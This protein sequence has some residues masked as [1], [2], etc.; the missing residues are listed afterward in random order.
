MEYPKFSGFT[1]CRNSTGG[2]DHRKMRSLRA[3]RVLREVVTTPTERIRVKRIEPV[4]RIAW[5]SP[6]I[7]DEPASEARETGAQLRQTV[8]GAIN[9]KHRYLNL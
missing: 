8:S 5:A 4:I 6:K 3:I 1:N 7:V 9:S 2:F